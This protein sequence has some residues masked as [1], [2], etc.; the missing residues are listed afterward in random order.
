[1]FCSQRLGNKFQCIVPEWDPVAN[2]QLAPPEP[3]Q[4]FQPKRSRASTPIA[5]GDRDK[6]RRAKRAYFRSVHL[7]G[8]QSLGELKRLLCT[9][10]VVEAPPRGEDDAINV[11]WR[12]TDKY[13]DES[14]E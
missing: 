12:P 13:S 10:S 14:R 8:A 2:K 6:A 3:R 4:Y 5:K 9:W 11:I 1:M 7:F